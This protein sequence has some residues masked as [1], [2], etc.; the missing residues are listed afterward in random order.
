GGGSRLSSVYE[1][2]PWR[3]DCEERAAGG[4]NLQRPIFSRCGVDRLYARERFLYEFSLARRRSGRS[5]RKKSRARLLFFQG[6][7][8]QSGVDKLYRWTE[9]GGFGPRA[10]RGAQKRIYPV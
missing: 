2:V 6:R 9:P 3:A 7:Q 4:R 10:C 1:P 8:V 5:G